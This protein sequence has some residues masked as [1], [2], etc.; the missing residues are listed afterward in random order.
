M[1]WKG[2]LCPVIFPVLSLSTVLLLYRNNEQ[3]YFT[4]NLYVGEMNGVLLRR[5]LSHVPFYLLWGNYLI[6]VINRKVRKPFLSGNTKWCHRRRVCDVQQA[7]AHHHPP[8]PTHPDILDWCLGLPCVC[9]CATHLTNVTLLT[10][11]VRTGLQSTL[12]DRDSMGC[13]PW[14]G[15]AGDLVP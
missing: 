15:E 10:G 12:I 5:W 3:W 13:L 8:I 6:E 14:V 1:E 11:F 7:T 2:T 4:L 9:E